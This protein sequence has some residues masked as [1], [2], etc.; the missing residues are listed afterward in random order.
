MRQDHHWQIE[1]ST[2]EGQHTF[3]DHHAD[4]HAAARRE[5][6]ASGRGRS[7][8]FLHNNERDILGLSVKVYNIYIQIFKSDEKSQKFHDRETSKYW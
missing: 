4:T 5:A 1:D 6:V 7:N 2:P 8:H 3:A